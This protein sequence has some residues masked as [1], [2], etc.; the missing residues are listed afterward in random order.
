MAGS[1]QSTLLTE[2]CELREEIRLYLGRREKSKTLVYAIALAIVGL[3]FSK[4]FPYD[5]LLFPAAALLTY[6]L[7]FDEIRRI[8]AVFRAATYIE[9]FI[10][11]RLEGLN[12]ETY[13]RHH[14]IQ[15]TW[16]P[17]LGSNAQYP[18]IFIGMVAITVIRVFPEQC[19]VAYSIAAIGLLMAVLLTA[20][21]YQVSKNGRDR[22]KAAW[23]AIN[24]RIKGDNESSN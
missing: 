3:D 21:A 14:S 22:E 7:W 8:M 1:I 11:P 17:R 2:Y 19:F 20:H 13:S 4:A 10:E 6:F 5:I 16:L 15:S 18:L 12:W 24:K 9:I 23:S